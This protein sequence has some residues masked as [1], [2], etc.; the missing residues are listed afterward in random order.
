MFPTEL[1][2]A[3]VLYYT[4]RG[5][6]GAIKHPDGNVADYYHYLAICKY[7]KDDNYYLFCC[8]ENYEVVSDWMAGSIEDCKKSAALS[9]KEAVI[10]NEVAKRCTDR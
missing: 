8:N 9:Y 5:D 6:Y 10:W 7:P 2:G 3:D 4:P 1:D